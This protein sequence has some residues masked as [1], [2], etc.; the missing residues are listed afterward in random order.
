MG[1]A[2][3]YQSASGQELPAIAYQSASG[4]KL[5]QSPKSLSII[6]INIKEKQVWEQKRKHQTVHLLPFPM[7]YNLL[8]SV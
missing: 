4:Q 6:M 3:A 8:N 1:S 2:T 7:I 5:P